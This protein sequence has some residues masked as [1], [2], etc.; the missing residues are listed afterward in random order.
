MTHQHHSC[1]IRNAYDT[2]FN[3]C[4]SF[5]KRSLCAC[6][7]GT[8][9]QKVTPTSFSSEFCIVRM[10]RCGHLRQAFR[11][12][13]HAYLLYT[14]RTRIINPFPRNHN[15]LPGTIGTTHD[16]SRRTFLLLHHLLHCSFFILSLSSNHELIPSTKDPFSTRN[17]RVVKLQG[18][19]VGCSVLVLLLLLLLLLL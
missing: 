9:Y 8:F 12:P 4:A 6:R 2:Y 13:K 3:A 17:L 14:Y 1:T 15:V 10:A 5:W 16:T 7:A 11:S 19:K 18:Q